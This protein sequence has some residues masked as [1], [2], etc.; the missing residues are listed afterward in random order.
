MPGLA[1]HPIYKNE[2][3]SWQGVQN[4]TYASVINGFYT[5]IPLKQ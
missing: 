5:Y 2:T 3:F 4:Y 1:L